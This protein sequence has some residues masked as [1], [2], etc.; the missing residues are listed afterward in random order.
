MH[1]RLASPCAFYHPEFDVQCVLHGDDLTFL[2]TDSSLDEV[3]SAMKKRYEVKI[4]G[5]LGPGPEDDKS[6]RILIR[7][8]EWTPGVL[9]YEA[10]QRHSEIIVEQLGFAKSNATL[11]LRLELSLKLISKTMKPAMITDRRFTENWWPELKNVAADRP[12]IQYA[13][14][15]LAKDMP[16]PKRSSWAALERLGKHLKRRPRSTI[17]FRYQA[18]AS[19]IHPLMLIGLATKALERAQVVE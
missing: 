7:I 19:T 6:I 12:D 2:G 8:L 17:M 9:V 13:V 15:E 1:Q 11:S 18:S 10:D 4:R 3:Q 16:K 5:R 14:K